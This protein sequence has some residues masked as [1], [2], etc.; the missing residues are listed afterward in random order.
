[1]TIDSV[2]NFISVVGT[3]IGVSEWLIIDQEMIDSF[4]DA[5]LDHQWIH[6]D[7]EKAASE[8]PYHTTIAHGYLTLSLLPHFLEQILHVDNLERLVNYGIEKMVFKNVVT[9]DSRLRMRATLKGAKDLGN[10]CLATIQCVFEVED[11]EDP[12][13][14]GSIKYLYYF[15]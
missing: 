9:V 5:T 12:V 6:V 10:I 13:L 15:K 1:M 3:E 11:Q 14:E 8:S 7:I 2:E 4:A